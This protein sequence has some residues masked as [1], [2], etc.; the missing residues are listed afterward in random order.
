[1][2]R[3]RSR[4]KVEENNLKIKAYFKSRNEVENETRLNL[5]N[6]SFNSRNRQVI[7]YFRIRTFNLKLIFK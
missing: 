7:E 3:G 5:K 6:N 2:H 1:M 4:L